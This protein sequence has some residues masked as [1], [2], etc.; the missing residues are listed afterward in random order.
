MGVAL[1]I[2]AL[3]VGLFIGLVGIGGVFLPPLLVASGSTLESAIGTSLLTFALSGIV[4][5]VIYGRRGG[6]DWRGALLTSA[7]SIVGGLLGARLGQY[8]PSTVVLACFTAFLLF[9]GV[10]AL[11]KRRDA[12][13]RADGDVRLNSWVLL[14]CGLFVGVGSGLTGVGGP[15]ILVPLLLVLRVPV[16][17]AVGISQP[18][19][20]AA[21]AAGA[22][23]HLLFGHLDLHLALILG[24]V[25]AAG[26]AAGSI[27]HTRFHT[28]VLRRVVALMAIA[29]GIWLTGQIVLHTRP[30]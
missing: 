15:A 27:L 18:N 14:A 21:S 9:A 7:G 26:V 13:V 2:G 16:S 8:L 19:Q 23:G 17:V 25:T 24:A 10:S 1:A 29:L 30:G 4:A 20:I 3:V 28:D 6:I 11:A 22:V 5:T 12:G